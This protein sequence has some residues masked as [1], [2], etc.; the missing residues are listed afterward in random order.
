MHKRDGNVLM[1]RLHSIHVYQKSRRAKIFSFFCFSP[2]VLTN[3]KVHG[4]VSIDLDEQVLRS[5]GLTSFCA[6]LLAMQSGLN[7]HRG[8]FC[9]GV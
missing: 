7:L 4:K 2:V 3:Y 1:I 5:V 8:L 9:T 6:H